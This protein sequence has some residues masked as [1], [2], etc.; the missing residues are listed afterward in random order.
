MRPIVHFTRHVSLAVEGGVDWVQDDAAGT[1]GTLVKVTVAPQ[2]SINNRWGS[3]PVV[4]AFVTGASWTT[5][6][7]G[8][9][10]GTDYATEKE[11]LTAGMQME[12]WW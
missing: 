2:V 6:F 5:D 7:V 8:S 4:R 12:A 11:G 1:E 10:G 9:V 3:R